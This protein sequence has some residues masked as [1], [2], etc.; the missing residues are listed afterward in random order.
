[1]IVQF[2][3]KGPDFGEVISAQLL[4][5]IKVEQYGTGWFINE[6][7]IT[8]EDRKLAREGMARAKEAIRTAEAEL[9]V[10]DEINVAM[11]F[12]LIRTEEVLELIASKPKR[13]ELVLTGRRAPKEIMK[14]AD[15]VTEMRKKKHPFDI[16]QEGRPGIEF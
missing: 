4:P 13:V 3:K 14:R 5:R 7:D 10:L 12:K 9:I 8:D 16:G 2:L 6:K 11:Y 1:M 15:Y